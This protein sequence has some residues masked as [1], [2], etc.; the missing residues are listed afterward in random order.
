MTAAAETAKSPPIQNLTGIRKSAILLVLL[1]D[2]AA[3]LVYRNL[4]EEDLQ[5]LT[6]EISELQYIS[7]EIGAQIL[8][9]YYRL[10]VTE[11]YLAQG[12]ADYAKTL[13]VKAFGED[14][15]KTLL[16]Q[17]E[18]YQE[19]RATNLDSLQRADPQQLVMFVEGEHP[20]TIALV[21]A[22]MGLKSASE[23]LLLLPEKTRAEVVRRLAE[24]H[25][26]SPEMV[27]K[28]AL[29]LNKKLKALGEQNRRA[30]G[31]I[32]A[33]SEM[34]NRVEPNSVKA[35]L[36]T[37][38]QDDPKLAL[39]IRNLMFTF[40]DFLSVPESSMRELLS[41][42]DKKTLAV[43]LK[44]SSEDMKNHIFKTM[45]SR[46]SQMLK[47]DMEALGPVRSREVATAQ[48]DV[49]QQARKLEADGKLTLKSFG[50]DAYVV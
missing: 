11:E 26:F 36:E 6:E 20:Q 4:P 31:G 34:L 15:A 9:E 30:Y 43:A 16:K 1:G 22:H 8:Q 32:K 5:L 40:E 23:V 7:P 13:L 39:S 24:M 41:H 48:Q 29:V 17:V 25:Q 37:I 38:E 44:G 50:D 19:A 28:I 21:L 35:I 46:A 10:T 12:G 3:S 49:V 14:G 27:Q 33:V 2:E 45:S 47:E 18:N 42:L